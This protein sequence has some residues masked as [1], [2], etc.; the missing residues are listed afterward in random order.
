M[1]VGQVKKIR[2]G[3]SAKQEARGGPGGAR[4]G[5][6]LKLGGLLWKVR[7]EAKSPTELGICGSSFPLVEGLGA[8]GFGECLSMIP[9]APSHS[10]GSLL[11]LQ[12]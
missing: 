11:R 4:R 9:G 7:G 3:V 5:R 12:S 6:G 1:G 10:P 2:P 8:A